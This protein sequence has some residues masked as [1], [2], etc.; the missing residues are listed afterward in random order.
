[1]NSKKITKNDLID[2]IR[3]DTGHE[4]RVV[5]EVFDSLLENIKNTLKEGDTIELR[6]FGTFDLRLRQSRQKARNPKTGEQLSIPSHY[7][8]VFRSGQELKKAVWELPIKEK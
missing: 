5:Q 6:R 4:K 3:Q 7:V 1:M 8:V 2:L